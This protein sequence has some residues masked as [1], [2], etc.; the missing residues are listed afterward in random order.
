MKLSLSVLAIIFIHQTAVA[1]IME[2]PFLPLPS[3]APAPKDNP[4]TA[5][6]RW[7]SASN[8]TL[9]PVSPKTE[10]FLVIRVT[11]S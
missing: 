11:T 9:I 7:N 2:T 6:R 5:S 1:K 8:F 3:K 10:Q 4:T